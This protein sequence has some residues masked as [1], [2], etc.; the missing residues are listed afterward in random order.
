MIP[1]SSERILILFKRS[2]TAVD[3]DSDGLSIHTQVYSDPDFLTKYNE[4]KEFSAKSFKGAIYIIGGTNSERKV[5]SKVSP[6]Y[7]I[8]EEMPEMNIKRQGA[9][10]AELNGLLYVAGGYNYDQRWLRSVEC[11]NP[12]T[13]T[14]TLV[15]YMNHV[16]YLAAMVAHQGRLYITGG[17]SG[18]R[19]TMEVYCPETDLWTD[20]DTKLVFSGRIGGAFVMKN[21]DLSFCD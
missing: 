1:S 11:Y 18:R 5:Q 19:D 12:A 16:R 3:I 17:C 2:I 7:S 4:L 9:S 13:H 6:L 8:S 10:V 20:I 15:A 21:Y 14:W